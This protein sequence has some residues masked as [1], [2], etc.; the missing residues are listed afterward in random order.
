[1]F[2]LNI[3]Y[4][5]SVIHLLALSLY[6]DDIERSRKFNLRVS[7]V[8][9]GSSSRQ[10]LRDDSVSCLITSLLYICRT[11]SQCVLIVYIEK[12]HPV[13]MR[14]YYYILLR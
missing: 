11:H 3:I 5:Q 13:M 1:M 7:I 8:V 6:N 4:I 10:L 9:R 2:P 14:L 12:N